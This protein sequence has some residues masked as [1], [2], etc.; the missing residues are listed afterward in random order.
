[1]EK[2]TSQS[3]LTT[4]WSRKTNS[5]ALGTLNQVL[6]EDFTSRCIVRAYYSGAHPTGVGVG[7]LVG[8]GIPQAYTGVENKGRARRHSYG[9][10]QQVGPVQ[11]GPAHSELKYTYQY[12]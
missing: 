8:S 3:R 9:S 4:G 5:S 2:D 11:S 10:W 1:V 6:I 7:I 12:K